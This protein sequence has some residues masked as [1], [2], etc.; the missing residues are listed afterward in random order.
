MRDP[1]PLGAAEA[2]HALAD[3][4]EASLRHELLAAWY[5]RV[6]DTVF[7]GYRTQWDA[8]WEASDNDTRMIVTQARHTWT[9]AKAA[10]FFREDTSY[11]A[12]S[13][14][15]FHFLRDRMWDAEYGGFFWR[16]GTDGTPLVEG[17]GSP[18][19][20]AYGQAFGIYALAAYHAASRNEE[21]LRLAQR[22]FHWL[23]AN[24][25]D[26]AFGGYFQNLGRDGTP[27]AP[28]AVG[29]PPKDQNSSIHLLEAF[30]E[31]YPL[32]PDSLLGARLGELLEIIRD[33]ITGDNAYLTLFSHADWRP[34]LPLDS[35][36]I[37]VRGGPMDHVSFGH[38]VE[39]AF[40]MLE[41]AAVLG[42]DPSATIERG[43]A[44]VDHALRWGWDDRLGG[45]Y[46]AGEY[47][48]SRTE[49]TITQD[50]KNWWTQA[51]GLNSLLLLG[52]RCPGDSLAY[53]EK[54]LRQWAY[55]EAHLIDHERGGWYVAGTDTDPGAAERD[56]G[57]IWKG[58]YHDGRALMNV[59]RRLRGGQD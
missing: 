18:A 39:T 14:H 6:V 38:D 23:D 49:V 57:S 15:G 19:K 47:D 17:P 51:E 44:M 50:G 32:W 33:T 53:H 59:I 45:F 5:P 22:A 58:A 1:G 2:R 40:L 21:A 4:I 41:A 31:L 9:T 52:D 46:D 12:M 54:F 36:G 13:A 34:Y 10:Q 43:K 42:I 26:S 56:K 3:E 27:L 37:P 35:T 29:L 16:V 25:H 48:E 8:D 30:T 28:G 11:L 7:G 55:I 24:A 20:Q